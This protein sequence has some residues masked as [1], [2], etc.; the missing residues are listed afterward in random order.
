MIFQ[1]R[2]KTGCLDLE[3]IESA[4]RSAMHRDGAA[5][6]SELLQFPAPTIDQRSLC[7]SCG[8]EAHYRELR[9]KPVLIAVG[10]VT[11]LRPYYLCPH[12]NVG[13]FPADTELDIENT[14]SSPAVRRMHALVGQQDPFDRGREQLKVLAGLQVTTKAV[15]RT[16]ETTHRDGPGTRD[17]AEN[18]RIARD[19]LA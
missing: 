13:Q 14:E 5:A 6:L 15:E 19:P 8:H 18:R 9:T 17:P 2:R 4:V 1:G 16:A 10:T 12:C 3:A 11:V 7:C